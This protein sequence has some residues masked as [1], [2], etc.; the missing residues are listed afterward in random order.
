[1]P[2]LSDEAKAYLIR[3]DGYENEYYVIENR[4]QKGWDAGLPGSGVIIFHIDYDPSVWASTDVCPN[5]YAYTSKGLSFPES[6]MYTIFP[7][8]GNT[9]TAYTNRWAYPY[10]GNDELTNTS[11]PSSTLFHENSD[12]EPPHE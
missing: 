8:N 7:A 10:Q 9:S 12:G 5:H 2:A 6:K 1:M 11:N 4:Q 3:N